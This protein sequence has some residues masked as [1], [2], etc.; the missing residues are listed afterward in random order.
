MGKGYWSLLCCLLILPLLLASCK[1]TK[2]EEEKTENLI[3]K[4]MLQGIWV[5]DE[6]DMPF[7]KIVGD[8]IYYPD[9]ENLTASFFIIEDSLYVVGSDTIPYAIDLQTEARFRFHQ[10]AD[11][12]IALYHS[13]T[14]EDSLYFI[15]K[16]EPLP[17]VTERIE[18]DSVVM[19]NGKRYRGY[20]FVNPSKMRVI[21]TSIGPSGMLVD[22]VYYD[23]V[24]H[25]CVYTGATELYGRDITKQLF[26]EYIPSDFLSTSI[27]ADMDFKGVDA[28]G[29]HYEALVGDP[30]SSVAAAYQL[31]LT[32][33][34]EKE[35]RIE[36]AQ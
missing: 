4:Q 34:P 25:I 32:I 13:E 28:E 11:N 19:Y 20:V 15:N 30:E 21:K 33:T 18:K 29:Y 27:L 35:M 2:K 17:L 6:T 16:Q 5:D 8:S 23:N 14:D 36:L 1:E 24:I 12:V 9:A 22:N 26:A 7:M 31:D 10:F 3:A